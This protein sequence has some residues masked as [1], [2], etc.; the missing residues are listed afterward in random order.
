MLNSCTVLFVDREA[1][2]GNVFAGARTIHLRRKGR[3]E[4][5]RVVN[6]LKS[7]CDTARSVVLGLRG[8][9]WGYIRV[10]TEAKRNL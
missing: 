6:S 2:C 3:V 9:L 10:Q 5:R 7:V 8:Y 1:L 4:F